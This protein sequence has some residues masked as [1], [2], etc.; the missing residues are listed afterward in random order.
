[1]KARRSR[2]KDRF[3]ALLRRLKAGGRQKVKKS[4]LKPLKGVFKTLKIRW[5][6]IFQPHAYATYPNTVI[7]SHRSVN[8]LL[9][10]LRFPLPV[11]RRRILHFILLLGTLYTSMLFHPLYK[12]TNLTVP[13]LPN[14][15]IGPDSFQCFI[16]AD[17]RIRTYPVLLLRQLSP[18]AG[19]HQHGRQQVG[20]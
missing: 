4:F 20:T 17:G 11:P 8:F 19:L 3:I 7:I 14:R 2:S 18:A 1:M 6:V 12:I 10:P 15:T 5:V 16:G 9:G 13:R